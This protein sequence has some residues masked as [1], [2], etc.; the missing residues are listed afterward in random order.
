[1]QSNLRG[2]LTLSKP[3][4]MQEEDLI[5]AVARSL[6]L[7]TPRELDQLGAT[8]YPAMVNTA[9]VA[10]DTNKVRISFEVSNI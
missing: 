3:A 4:E 8:L 10:Q 5:E 6:R 1:M 9:V 7:S 2:E